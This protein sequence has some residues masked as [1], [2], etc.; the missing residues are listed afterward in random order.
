M[1]IT[2]G[3]PG[4]RVGESECQLVRKFIWLGSIVI[5]E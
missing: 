4:A 1:E 5:E 2:F 3:I